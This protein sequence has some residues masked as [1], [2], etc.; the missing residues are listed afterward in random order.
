MKLGGPY[1]FWTVGQEDT[2]VWEMATLQQRTP[3]WTERDDQSK[4]QSDAISS[5]EAM[6]TLGSALV[7]PLI[8]SLQTAGVIPCLGQPQALDGLMGPIPRTVE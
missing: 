1:L 3:G 2:C 5:T 4:G 6:N 7:G 8:N